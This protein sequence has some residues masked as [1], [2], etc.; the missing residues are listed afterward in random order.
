MQMYSPC[1]KELVCICIHLVLRNSVYMCSLCFKE[2]SVY[3]YSPCFKELVCICIHFVLRN[4]VCICIRLVLRVY[5][6]QY[7]MYAP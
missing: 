4:I 2:Y 3:M 7:G 6:P 5:I 1:F